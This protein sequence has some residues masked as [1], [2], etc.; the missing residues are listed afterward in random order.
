MKTF[1]SFVLMLGLFVSTGT[2]Q[3]S[4]FAVKKS[5]EDRFKVIAGMMDSANALPQ[6]DSAK[7][8]IDQLQSDFVRHEAFLDKALYPSTFSERMASLRSLH[9]LTYDRIYLIQT[10]GIKLSEMESRLASLTSRLD[11]LT[12]Q[13]DQLFGELQESKKSLNA[14]REAVRRLSSNLTAKDKLIFALVDSIFQ[15]Y[16][17][18]LQ[19]VADVHKEAISQKLEKANV[20]TRIYEIASDNVKF[21]EVTQLQG[22]DYAS[23]IDQY[24]TFTNRWAGLREKIA[25]V[26]AVSQ[27]LPAQA[28]KK[29]MGQ[30]GAKTIS[31]AEK[32]AGASETEHVDS[33]L[34]EWRTKLNGTFWASLAREFSNAGVSVAP[35]N[36]APSFSASIRSY[37]ASARSN[38]VDPAPF[39]ETVWKEKIDKEWRDALSKESM[40]GKVEYAALDKQVSE[41]AREGIDVKLILYIA[42]VIAIVILVWILLSR[43]KKRDTPEAQST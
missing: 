12:T 25:A 30:K 11:S 13:R 19:Q 17:S 28:G 37:V 22:K 2:A 3:L 41:L 40:L 15:P 32:P 6:L 21:L 38:N 9:V 42:A 14:L 34:T 24:Q 4:D 31:Q 20:V 5:F 29:Q 39:V 35:F 10:Q 27:P 36:D 7:L 26:G 23:V 33:V 8:A 16:G 1:L 18:N 43:R